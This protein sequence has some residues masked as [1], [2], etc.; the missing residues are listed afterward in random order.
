MAIVWA[1]VSGVI[2][3]ALARRDEKDSTLALKALLAQ[4]PPP[5]PALIAIA[6]LAERGE[7]AELDLPE[8]TL[9]QKDPEL[10]ALAVSVLASSRKPR[11]RELLIKTMRENADARTQVRAASALVAGLRRVEPSK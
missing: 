7:E 2:R 3:R 1:I 6:A 10:K 8:I 9:G 4:S 5:E 11:A